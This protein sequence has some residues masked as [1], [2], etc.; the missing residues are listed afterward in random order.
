MKYVP[1]SFSMHGAILNYVK[2]YKHVLEHAFAC[3]QDF[4][5]YNQVIFQL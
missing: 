2:H 1:T 3:Y 5:L 4:G